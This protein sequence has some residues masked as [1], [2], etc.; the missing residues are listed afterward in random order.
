[1]RRF[2]PPLGVTLPPPSSTTRRLVL[3]T[4]AV[5]F[6]TILTLPGPQRKRITPPFATART[7]AR[8]VQLRAVP[9]PTQRSGCEVLTARASGGTGTAA[10]AVAGATRRAAQM[11]VRPTRIEP[12]AYAPRRRPAASTPTAR[13]TDPRP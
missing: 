13:S 9:W 6:I 12:P 8:E 4:L 5:A 2:P 7:T 11:V 1:M 3:T 10:A